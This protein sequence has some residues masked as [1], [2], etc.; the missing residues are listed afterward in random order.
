M[1]ILNGGAHADNGLEVQEFMIVPLG[2][3]NFAEALRA[4]VEVFHALKSN[5]KKDGLATS[6]GDEGGFAPRVGTIEEAIQRVLRSIEAA[7][8]KPGRRH[9]AGT[10]LR[11]PHACRP[12][13]RGKDRPAASG[14]GAVLSRARRGSS[15]RQTWVPALS[16][17]G[18][19]DA[20]RS[21]NDPGVCRSLFDS[22]Q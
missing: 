15:T 21:S 20:E 18:A 6:V 5:L 13:R 2:A 11:R 4:G 3:A 8:Y 7:G 19:G 12:R 10:R 22:D 9:R 14:G 17:A 1:N 16:L